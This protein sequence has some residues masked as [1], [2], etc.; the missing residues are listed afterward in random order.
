VNLNRTQFHTVFVCTANRFRSPLAAGV[1]RRAAPDLPLE[2]SSRGTLDVGRMPPL[3]QALRLAPEL[4]LDIS[5]HRA[6]VIGRGE[7]ANAD[8]VVGFEGAH[9][10]AAIAEGAAPAAAAFTLP[11]LV[12]LLDRIEHPP[13]LREPAESLRAL[14]GIAHRL[15]EQQQSENVGEIGDPIGKPERAFEQ[16]AEIIRE[17]AGSL[18]SHFSR[19]AG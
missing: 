12:R 2:I 16:T 7:L 8:L 1:L 4:G 10:V 11:E 18:A 17:L 13:T 5:T 3:I 9:V 6:R 15:R 19:A 14:I